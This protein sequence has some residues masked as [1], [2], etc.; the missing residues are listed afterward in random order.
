MT[1][2][3]LKPATP[4]L[5]VLDP[6]TLSPLPDDGVEVELNS[7]WQRR[8]NDGDVVIAEQAE[9]AKKGAAK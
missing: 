4:G 5:R 9:P 7:H 6:V 3:V 1:T 2:V 8:L